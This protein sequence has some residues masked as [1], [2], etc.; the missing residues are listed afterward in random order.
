[1]LER[2]SGY[3]VIKRPEWHDNEIW[4]RAAPSRIERQAQ[5]RSSIQ[6]GT[7]RTL[8]CIEEIELQ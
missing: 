2:R 5:F 4:R 7:L 3:V 6:S 8:L 1:L